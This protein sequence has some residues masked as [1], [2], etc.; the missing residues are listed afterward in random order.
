[1]SNLDKA[2]DLILPYTGYCDE[3]QRIGDACLDCIREATDAAQ[4]LAD[5]G[6]LAP[7][8]PEPLSVTNETEKRA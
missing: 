6:L 4:G 3:C 8:L 7:D 2:V 1:M 5:A